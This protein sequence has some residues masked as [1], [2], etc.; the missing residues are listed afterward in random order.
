MSVRVRRA[1]ED[2]LDGWDDLVR[3]SPHA[4]PF[5]LAGAMDVLAEHSSTTLHPLVGLVGE[6]T[7]GLLPVY[8]RGLGPVSGVFSPPPNLKV[9]SQGPVLLN[10]EKLKARKATRRHAAF[11]D[12]CL[13]YVDREIGPRYLL[14]RTPP[15]YDDARPLAWNGLSVTPR[16]TYAVDLRRG[17]DALLQ[18]FSGDARGNITGEYDPEVE[19]RQA[20]ADAIRR[21]VTQLRERHAEQG[22]SYPVTPE[23]V[24]ALYRTLPDGT[25]RPYE[26]TVDNEF[27]GG[28]ITVELGDTIYRWQGGAKTE[29][30]VPI[31]DLVDWHVISD[32]MERGRSRYDLVGANTRRLAGYKAK[33]A[34]ELEPYYEAVRSGVSMRAL[35]GIYKRLR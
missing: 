8:D 23:F 30:G 10:F 4:T 13:A 18:S 17:Q 14:V 25:V 19:I 34:P 24:Q 20:G 9:S 21:I 12:E 3:R 26:C 32:A 31:N 29:L 6:E 11:I 15:R 22:E 28:M 16:Y 33:F 2:E 35:A 5:H 27:A 7:V 1:T